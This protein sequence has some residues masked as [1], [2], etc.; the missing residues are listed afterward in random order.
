MASFLHVINLNWCVSLHAYIL[1]QLTQSFR[2]L[3]PRLAFLNARLLLSTI[4][5]AVS[6]AVS[7]SAYLA[8]SDV[9]WYVDNTY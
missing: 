2:F 9:I 6:S 4:P 1:S 8:I 7:L 5:Y 3:Y